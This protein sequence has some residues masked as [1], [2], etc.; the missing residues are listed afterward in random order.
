MYETTGQ[1]HKG[2]HTMLLPALLRPGKLG[3]HGGLPGWRGRGEEALRGLG[4]M[5]AESASTVGGCG[6]APH[7]LAPWPS[8]GPLP[9]QGRGDG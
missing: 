9:G 8:L 3:Y 1:E 5:E 4:G 2:T 7:W 6:L